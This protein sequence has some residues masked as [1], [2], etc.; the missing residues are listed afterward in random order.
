MRSW[1]PHEGRAHLYLH[2]RRYTS[3]WDTCAPD[4]ILHEA[5]GRMTDLLNV[6]LRYNSPEVRNL[7]GVIASNGAIHDRIVEAAK[8]ALTGTL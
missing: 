2:T 8:S 4:V 5:G 3:Q 6:P 7:H 1:K